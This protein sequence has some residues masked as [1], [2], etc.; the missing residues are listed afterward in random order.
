MGYMGRIADYAICST[1]YGARGRECGVAGE[2]LKAIP[3]R[4]SL[5]NIKALQKSKPLKFALYKG[6]QGLLVYTS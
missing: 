4:G 5:A 6:G 3:I 2:W 1:G